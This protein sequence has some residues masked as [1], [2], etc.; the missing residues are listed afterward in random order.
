MIQQA[1]I[2]PLIQIENSFTLGFINQ[3][4]DF[5]T[6]P[7]E[8]RNDQNSVYLLP[9][10][11]INLIEEEYILKEPEEIKRFLIPKLS[12]FYSHVN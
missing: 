4:P 11:L 10:N 7:A 5:F 3:E 8:E 2:N 9:Q 12:D 6:T 1:T